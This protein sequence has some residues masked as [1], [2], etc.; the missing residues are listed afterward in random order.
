MHAVQ[1]CN[2]LFWHGE[3]FEKVI[4]IWNKFAFNPIQASLAV[5]KVKQGAHCNPYVSMGLGGL[6]SQILV[7]TSFQT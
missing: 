3:E 2:G 1:T 4:F 7:A 6:Q 5:S